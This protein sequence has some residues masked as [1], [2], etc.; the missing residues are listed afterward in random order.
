MNF[1]NNQEMQLS[2]ENIEEIYDNKSNPKYTLENP[3][4]NL[5]PKLKMSYIINE[6]TASPPL[7]GGIFSTFDVEKN[8]NIK[9]YNYLETNLK[10]TE[11]I[12]NDNNVNTNQNNF[13][14]TNNNTYNIYN[15]VNN[16]QPNSNKNNTHFHFNNDL[17]NDFY[18]NYNDNNNYHNNINNIN[19]NNNY[20]S[21]TTTTTTT[22]TTTSG[23]QNINNNTNIQYENHLFSNE[24]QAHMELLTLETLRSILPN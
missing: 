14:Q 6:P 12:T 20:Y 5:G 19:N 24:E 21:A 15:H 17:N 2:L 9:Y 13:N 11:I 8:T 10:Q 4:Q 3:S 16:S 1:K 23:P 18:Y 22:T 7:F